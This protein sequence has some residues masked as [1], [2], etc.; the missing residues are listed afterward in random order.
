MDA[1]KLVS[2][3]E[4]LSEIDSVMAEIYVAKE[5]GCVSYTEIAKQLDITPSRV[6][7]L[8]TQAVR[9]LKEGNFLWM[10][11]L[12]TH[13]ITQLLKTKYKDA[14][15]LKHDVLTNKVD[16]EDLPNI[17]HKIAQEIYKWCVNHQDNPNYRCERRSYS[18]RSS[19]R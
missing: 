2:E 16:L 3:T 4:T 14:E 12:S 17:G 5:L 19:D 6:C 9:I 1:A 7:H 8:H 11:G 10:E 15:S 13:A 18:R